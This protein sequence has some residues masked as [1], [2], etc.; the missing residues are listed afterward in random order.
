MSYSQPPV[1]RCRC[2]ALGQLMTPARSKT[3]LSETAKS[4]ITLWYK[5]Q[6]YARRKEISSKYMTKGND[7]EEAS[8]AYLNSLYGTD[9]K[10]NEQ[11]FEDEYMHGTPDVIGE[12]IIIDIKNSWDFSTFP[13]FSNSLPNKD[14]R[15]QVT[16]YMMLTGKK[17]GSVVYTLMDTPDDIIAQEWRSAGNY[18]QPVSDEFKA[19]YK[20]DDIT[21]SKLRI[22]RFDFDYDETLATEIVDKVEEAR[23]FISCL[24]Y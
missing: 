20:Y 16:G 22:K 12:D 5:E 8:I 17:K 7:C 14:Y 9:Y 3:G 19:K 1:F 2:S 24:R 23:K 11:Y 4:F 13:L 18:N 6:L 15:L 10:K 21:D